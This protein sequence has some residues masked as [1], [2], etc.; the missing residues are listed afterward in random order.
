MPQRAVVYWLMAVI[1]TVCGVAS[2]GWL[3]FRGSDEPDSPPPFVPTV[4]TTTDQ[5]P[6]A[7]VAPGTTTTK[8]GTI[9]VPHR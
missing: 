8:A 5:R 3:L 6:A 2:L 4:V 9:S 7:P 1:A